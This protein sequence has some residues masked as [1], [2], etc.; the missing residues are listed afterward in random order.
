MV[1]LVL[2]SLIVALLLACSE[3][4]LEPKEGFIEVEGGKVWYQIV[5]S[6]NATPLLLL[7]GGPGATSH[8]L[9]P[10]EKVAVDRPVIFYDQLGAGRSPAPAD[11]SL[12][13]VERFV[14]ELAQVRA[15]LRLKE[16]HILGHSWGSMLAMDYMLTE[17][18][19]VKSLIFASPALNISRWTADARELLKALPEETQA[20]IEHH[21]REG[22]TDTP[23]YQEA[24]MDYYGLYLSRS[25]P[26][27]PHL[28]AAFEGFNT[29]LYGYMWGPSEFTA[30]GT[31]Q[32][33][34]REPDLPNLDLPVLFTAGRYD[35]ATPETV[36][37]FQSLVPNAEIRIFENSAHV[38]MLDEP[39]AYAGA[40]RS[41]L[42]NAERSR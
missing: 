26:W 9:K 29:E 25:D 31:L 17:P 18:E 13:T 35:E 14:K 10:L 41:F 34:N 42:N 28:L 40:I 24:V 15:A 20:V 3:T 36:R 7:H 4:G 1:R 33:Y 23:E 30:T 22:T 21:E 6:G 5:G 38:P 37:H 32:E 16:V 2:V 27:S 11:S 8:Y 39:D 19:G 12:W